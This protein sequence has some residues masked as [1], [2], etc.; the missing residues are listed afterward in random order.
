MANI[1][2]YASATP[3]STDDLLGTDDPDGTPLTRNFAIQAVLGVIEFGS[4]YVTGGAAGQ[5][6][7]A[8]Y[9]LLTEFAAD[10]DSSAGVTPTVASNKITIANTGFYFVMAALSFENDTAELTSFR[11]Y[12]NAVAQTQL[13]AIIDINNTNE[14]YNAVLCGFVDVTTG[15]TDLDLRA[16]APAGAVTV[17]EGSLTIV[18]V[19]NT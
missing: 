11:V 3:V 7:G 1:E 15:A 9:A 17:K 18:R 12:W 13:T 10:G 5:S 16:I 4:I 8:A 6:P 2:T 19:G 14:E